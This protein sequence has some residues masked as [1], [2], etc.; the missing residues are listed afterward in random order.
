M[1]LAPSPSVSVIFQDQIDSLLSG[2]IA[3]QEA[4]AG[5]VACLFGFFLIATLYNFFKDRV[6]LHFY[7][8]I[9]TAS[10]TP[11]LSLC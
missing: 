10:K 1:A 4:A 8:L 5:V 7:L 9:F 11:R 3:G 6:K 2:S